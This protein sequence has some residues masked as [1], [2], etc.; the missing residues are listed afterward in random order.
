MAKRRKAKPTAKR[1]RKA[2][3]VTRRRR[4]VAP[5]EEIFIPKSSRSRAGPAAPVEAED[6]GDA[7]FVARPG[8]PVEVQSDWTDDAPDDAGGVDNESYFESVGA[9][10]A[11]TAD[12]WTAEG[13]RAAG[14]I[15]E[16]GAVRCLFGCVGTTSAIVGVAMHAYDCTFWN[17]EAGKRTQPF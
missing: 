9:S 14:L 8:R 7:V 12:G 1:P 16:R 4:A 5:V 10:R 3:P 6:D 13:L 11:M 2:A 15:V 17:T